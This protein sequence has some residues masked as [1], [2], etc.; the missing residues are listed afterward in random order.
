MRSINGLKESKESKYA[1]DQFNLCKQSYIK[2]H[3]GRPLEKL[4]VIIQF[5]LVFFFFLNFEFFFFSFSLK[6]LNKELN[7]VLNM[8][9]YHTKWICR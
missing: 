7:V 1:K 9:I 4:H 3:F 2:E 8:K 5:F 6:K